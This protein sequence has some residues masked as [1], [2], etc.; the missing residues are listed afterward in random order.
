M[1]HEEYSTARQSFIPMPK[2]QFA[3]PR[4]DTGGSDRAMQM[5][6]GARHFSQV[7]Q[8]FGDS[9]TKSKQTTARLPDGMPSMHQTSIV[10]KTSHG[11]HEINSGRI[12]VNIPRGPVTQQQ[13]RPRRVEKKLIVL[14]GR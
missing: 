1:V 9:T 7:Q 13:Q 5:S 8:E 6:F 2:N 12:D 10:D 3:N 14:D 4:Y 11:T